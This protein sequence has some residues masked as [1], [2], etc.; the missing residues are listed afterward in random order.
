MFVESWLIYY[1]HQTA[2]MIWQ[3]ILKVNFCP[4]I[5]MKF[6]IFYTF[7]IA[8]WKYE[9][10]IELSVQD[11]HFDELAN[12]E[13]VMMNQQIWLIKKFRVSFKEQDCKAL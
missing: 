1:A 2:L 13:C 6:P 11:V 7:F 10:T 5:R 3:F 9:S 8:I 4:S 12:H